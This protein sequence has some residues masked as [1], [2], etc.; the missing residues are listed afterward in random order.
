MT[1]V[2]CGSGNNRRVSALFQQMAESWAGDLFS[3]P[4]SRRDRCRHGWLVPRPQSDAAGREGQFFG[5]VITC[6]VSRNSR[7]SQSKL[8]PDAP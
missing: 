5:R 3:D 1:F 2:E 8:G 7:P 6:R 4:G